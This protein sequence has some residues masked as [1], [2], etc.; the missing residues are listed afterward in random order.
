VFQAISSTSAST[1]AALSATVRVMTVVSRAA[2]A[3]AMADCGMPSI[4]S[5]TAV[6]RLGDLPDLCLSQAKDQ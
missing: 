2:G 4:V 6:R 5:R 1:A 3:C